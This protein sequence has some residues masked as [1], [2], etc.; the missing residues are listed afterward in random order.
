MASTYIL[1]VLAAPLLLRQQ[2]TQQAWLLVLLFGFIIIISLS[3]T[4]T[5]T[6]IQAYSTIQAIVPSARVLEGVIPH[7]SLSSSTSSD[8]LNSCVTSKK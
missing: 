3:S 5:H 2:M 1:G 4:H 6:H 8:Q 7:N